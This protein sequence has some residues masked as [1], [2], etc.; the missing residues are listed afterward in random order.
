MYY[1]YIL[2]CKDSSYYTG[3]TTHIHRRMNEHINKTR[4]CAKYTYSHDVDNLEAIWISENR[5]TAS[6]LEYH[7]KKLSKKEKIK[8]IEENQFDLLPKIDKHLY[9]RVIFEKE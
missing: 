3:I 1:T 9:Q 8:L 6:K 7:I 2:K 5:S 4:R